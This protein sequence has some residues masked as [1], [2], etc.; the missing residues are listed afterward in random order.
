[1]RS[2]RTWAGRLGVEPNSSYSD[3][4]TLTPAQCQVVIDS[5]ERLVLGLLTEA[6]F[7]ERQS[8]AYTG[9][10]SAEI[11]SE[12]LLKQGHDL[13]ERVKKV[14][15]CLRAYH[16]QGQLLEML[17]DPIIVEMDGRVPFEI[18]NAFDSILNYGDS[19]ASGAH[20]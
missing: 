16:N 17:I 3:F 6:D 14:F 15:P 7:G 19:D 2:D 13:E 18:Q 1:M 5:V 12:Y 20:Y 8:V 10:M 9:G 11:S 4:R